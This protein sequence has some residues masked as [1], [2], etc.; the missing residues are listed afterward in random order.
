MLCELAIGQV[1]MK[2]LKIKEGLTRGPDMSDV[3]SSIWFFSNPICS[4]HTV[5]LEENLRDVYNNSDQQKT[6]VKASINLDQ[7]GIPEHYK[8]N[9]S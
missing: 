1:L 7:S 2:S 3:T 8:W 6:C 5:M 9:S 4:K